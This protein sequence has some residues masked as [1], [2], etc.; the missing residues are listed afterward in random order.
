MD[1]FQFK[2]FVSVVEQ[3]SFTKAAFEVS[4]SQSALSK[5]ISKLED[6]LHVQ[7]FDRSKRSATLTP[8]GRVFEAH[9]R[10]MLREQDAML[11]AMRS[12]STSGHLHIGSVDHMGRVGLTAPISSFLNQY[13]DG[14]VTIDI[15]KGDTLKLMDQLMAG[16]IDMAFIAHIISPISKASNI[17]A[18]QL[19][20]Y[21]LYTLVQDEYH[22]IVSKQHKFADRQLLSW[23]DLVS[24]RLVILDKGYSSNTIIR[25]S[26]RQCGL[27]P[28]IAFECDQVDTI[29]GMVEENFGISILS[30]RIATTRYDVAAVP[31]DAPIARNTVLVISKKVETHQR[32]AGE[33]ARHIIDYYDALSHQPQ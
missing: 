28:N 30:K 13:S 18:Y 9:A 7:L 20:K 19:D 12:Y 6:E 2:C 10:Q 24:E 8:A 14:S 1:L 17:D 22:V 26:F 33:F 16:K 31:M 5:H 4:I 21:R 32:L 15:E 11:E 27:Q 25:E 29:L 3:K 23:K